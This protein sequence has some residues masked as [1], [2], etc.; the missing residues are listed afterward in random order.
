MI[1]IRSDLQAK[2]QE[3]WAPPEVFK[4][5]LSPD[6]IRFLLADELYNSEKQSF[7]GRVFGCNTYNALTYLKPK[8]DAILKYPY[9]V[10]GGNYFRTERPYMLHADTGISA[11]SALYR[12]IV[13][14]LAL[15]FKSTE[16]S[17]IQE[18]NTLAIMNQRWY[19]Q[20]AFF[21]RGYADDIVDKKKSEYNIPIVDYSGVYNIS[22]NNFSQDVYNFYF[23]HLLYENFYGMSI[24]ENLEWVPG[25]ALT[26]DRSNLHAG[27]NFDKANVSYKIG[28]TFFLEYADL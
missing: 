5:F 12:I 22:N 28:L 18:Y 1:S 26:F 25:D 19:N 24:A 21:M 9:K 8:L 11:D 15:G 3:R 23:D 13:L 10:T 2:L 14:P 6:D 27:S 20:A 4:N 17:H 16:A 7:Y